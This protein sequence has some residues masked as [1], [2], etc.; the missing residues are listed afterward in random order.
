MSLVDDLDPVRATGSPGGRPSDPGPLGPLPRLSRRQVRLEERLGAQ[1]PGPGP[2][3]MLAGL[4]D[5][6]VRGT[7]ADRFEVTWR[8]SGLGRPGAIAQLTWP[9]LGTRVGLGIEPPVAHAIVDRLLGFE[10][11]PAEGR[12]QVTPV[13]WG[14]LSFAIARALDRLD[15]RPGPLGPWDLAIERVGPDPFDPAGLGPIV[16]WRWRVRLG[17][18]SGW[19][20][21]WIPESLL[22][23]WLGDDPIAGVGPPIPVGR[24]A[25]L[26]GDWRAEAGRVAMPRG[27]GRLR[28]GSLLPIEGSPLKGTPRSPEG[29][30]ELALS[31]RS[32]RS[33]FLAHP[34][35]DSAAARLILRSTLVREPRPREAHAMPPPADP[36][37]GPGPL[38]PADVPVTLTVELGRIS[39]PLGRVAD[40]KPGAVLELGRHAREPVELT[41]GGRL[42]ARG[43]LVQ[44][45]TELG[46]RVTHVFL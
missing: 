44:I 10:R 46:V 43:E 28:A 39:L 16:T 7:S 14:I 4:A 22:A 5:L 42:I 35:P 29:T 36:H 12:L 27:L 17:S 24:L 21:L 11:L 32:G 9:R 13:E 33:R 41:S 45:D 40:L 25:E 38:A 20:R 34:A 8:G 26:A 1:G 23:T 31:D 3:T 30:V 15:R 18:A 2:A 37:P 19:A 6:M